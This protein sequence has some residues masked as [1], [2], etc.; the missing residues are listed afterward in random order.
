MSCLPDFQEKLSTKCQ[1]ES[2]R[3]RGTEFVAPITEK[4]PT[5]IFGKPKSNGFVTP[6]F[7]PIEDGSKSLSS[8][9]NPSTK[10][11]QPRRVSLTWLEL[12]TFTNE[13]ETNCTRVGVTVL[14]PGNSPPASCANGKLWSL[15][16]K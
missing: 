8:G 3:A 2:T 10:R 9:K 6:V 15:S 16:P 1:F 4:L 14:K 5:L 11:F 12:T 7:S 13:S